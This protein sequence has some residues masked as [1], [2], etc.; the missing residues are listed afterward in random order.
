MTHY[1][2]SSTYWIKLDVYKR[3]QSQ[4]QCFAIDCCHLGLNC[5]MNINRHLL[6]VF[7]SYSANVLTATQANR[8]CVFIKCCRNLT[9]LLR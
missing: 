6:C 8:F 2:T 1:K 3:K 9:S 7:F 5:D 4:N